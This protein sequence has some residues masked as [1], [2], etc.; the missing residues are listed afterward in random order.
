[1]AVA[2][3]S[4]GW[5]SA[6]ALATL[7]LSPAAVAQPVQTENGLVQGVKEGGA[8][9]FKGI[10]YAAPPIGALRWRP[11]V[12]PAG[13]SGI[14]PAD[15]FPPACVQRG[16]Y[17][18]D[19]P[20]EPTSEDCLYLNVWTPAGARERPLPVMVWI[21]GGGLV[22]GS[23]STPLYAGD[24]LIRHQVLVV[25]FNYRL[26]AFGFLAHPGL[27]RESARA[28][29]GNYGLLDQLAA[30]GWVKR[31]IAAFGG[32]PDNV[33]LFGQ[34]SGAISISALVASPLARGLFRRV[35]G[36]SGGL[37]EPVEAAAEFS[38]EGAE[39]VGRAF[40]ARLR[41]SSAA[42]L[43]AVPAN[44]IVAQPFHPQPVIDGYVLTETPYHAYSHGR[45]SAVDLLV[46]SNEGEG[47]YFAAGRTIG[48]ANLTTELQR[49]FPAPLVSLLG[50]SRPADDHAALG[51]FVAFESDLRFGWNMWA[52]ARLHAAQRGR[53][54]FLYRFA[55]QPPGERG[56]THGA[57]LAYVFGH[58]E[59]QARAWTPG[60]ARLSHRMAAYWTN[61]ATAGDPNGPGLP[62]WPAFTPSGERMLFIGDSIVAGTLRNERRLVT[63]DRVY[64][65]IRFAV[66]YGQTIAMAGLVVVLAAAWRIVGLVLRRARRAT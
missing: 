33:T 26:G 9:V 27:S 10:P 52:W 19:A 53:K 39:R 41:A 30:L 24:A 57:E 12:P 7:T 2:P 48:A 13:W 21:H 16:T 49:D 32:D 8:R 43:R 35:I 34:S 3:T 51:A 61:F 54:T 64:R 63:I 47:W 56:A 42:A 20:R 25:T 60:D 11:P 18:P 58:L 50:P 1:M 22:N 38:L 36:Q 17:P 6:V 15:R 44:E 55:H 23:G 46:G 37:F 31:N 14:A 59:P 40:A 62:E 65:G 28:V 66:Q 29:S 5:L 45:A 4:C